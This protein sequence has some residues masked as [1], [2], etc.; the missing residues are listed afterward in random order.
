MILRFSA[1]QLKRTQQSGEISFDFLPAS[2]EWNNKQ[3]QK[4]QQLLKKDVFLGISTHIVHG[5]GSACLFIPNWMV[6]FR[7][8]TS[9]PYFFSSSTLRQ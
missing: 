8:I 6:V 7:F 1:D 2:D 4:L 3:Q 9:F 5:R